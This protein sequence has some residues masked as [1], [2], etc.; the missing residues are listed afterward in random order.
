MRKYVAPLASMLGLAAVAAGVFVSR[1]A[2]PPP[3]AGVP[4]EQKFAR[5]LA[6]G[7]EF[8]LR[9]QSD[10]GAV[11]SDTY[12]TFKDGTALTPLALNSLQE[13]DFPD[14]AARQ[15]SG[16]FLARMVRPDG[17]IDEGSIGLDF[18]AYTAA[19]SVQALS[20]EDPAE[21]RKPRDAWLHF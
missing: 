10:D 5:A 12:G 9:H 2:A 7:V 6:R 3:P 13:A 15:K 11:R 17:S 8:L 4:L 1:P 20:R 21:F 16:R 18:P 19:L 14:V